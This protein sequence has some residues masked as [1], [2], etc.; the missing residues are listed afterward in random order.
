[1]KKEEEG[2]R[3]KNGKRREAIGEWR[4]AIGEWLGVLS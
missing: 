2:D 4:E 1:M 3:R